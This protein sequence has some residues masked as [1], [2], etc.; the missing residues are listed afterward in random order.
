[1]RLAETGF[2]H[3]PAPEPTPQQRAAYHQHYEL[4]SSLHMSHNGT[5][6]IIKRSGHL[7]IQPDGT[8]TPQENK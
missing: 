1:M 7:T 2:N 6:T 4:Q 3:P 5:A 8:T